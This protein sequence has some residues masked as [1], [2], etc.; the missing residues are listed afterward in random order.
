MIAVN[1]M[2]DRAVSNGIPS[3]LCQLLQINVHEDISVF[4]T[5]FSSGRPAKLPTL[6]IDL[7]LDATPTWCRLGNFSQEQRNFPSDFVSDPIRHGTAYQS[8]ACK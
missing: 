2:I 8:P 6:E 1:C 7:A 4:H 5:S 3:D